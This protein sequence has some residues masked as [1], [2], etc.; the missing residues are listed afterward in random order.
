MA[1]T[2]WQGTTG[3]WGTAGNWSNGVP[4]VSNTPAVFDGRSQQS[5]TSGLDQTGVVFLLKTTRAYRGSIGSS[6]SPLIWSGAAVNLF[7]VLRGTGQVYL[8]P[9]VTNQWCVV[10]GARAFFTNCTITHLVAKSGT[11]NCASTCSLNSYLYL[12]G[13][14]AVTTIEEQ[15]TT[16]LSP[17][18]CRMT[19]GK[20]V[21]KRIWNVADTTC[22]ISNGVIEQTGVLGDFFTLDMHGGFFRYKPLASVVG[23]DPQ[24]NIW[25][26]LFDFSGSDQVLTVGAIAIGVDGAIIGS[27]LQTVESLMAGAS[28]VD[29]R[30][31]FPAFV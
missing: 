3:N 27:P 29:F 18:I 7:N 14:G 19:A 23:H 28:A 21:N 17:T 12:L 6:G 24:I 20:L 9:I 10:D 30:L 5:V 13:V 22:V 31:D 26:G 2:Y 4:S 15:A 1:A 25:N 16:E 8:Q 11:I